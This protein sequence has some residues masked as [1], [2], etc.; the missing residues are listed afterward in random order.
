MSVQKFI[1]DNK[2]FQDRGWIHFASDPKLLEWVS[3][4]LP[5]ATSCVTDP[6]YQQWLRH[7][8]TWFVGVNALN[9]DLNGKVTGGVNLS[10][11]AV[12]FIQS[13]LSRKFVWDRA[14]VS[15][16]YPGYPART[17]EESE[18]SFNY[19]LRRDAAHVDGLLREGPQQRRF[20]REHHAFIMGIPMQEV[21]ATAAPV[22]VWEGSHHL[23]RE[24]FQ[25]I[26]QGHPPDTWKDIDVTQAY[27]ELRKTIFSRCTRLE[28]P[29]RP[30]ECYLI[31][32]LALHGMAPWRAAT[33]GYES[34]RM[35][36]YFRPELPA[37]S[38]W[39]SLP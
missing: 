4:S 29:A 33:R 12:D 37:P 30:G 10:G 18:S 27:T 15:V 34:G 11:K 14:Q 3:L 26:Y 36:C 39:L 22:V 21:P 17:D 1:E 7:G 31:H 6:E 28:L 32:R 9:N 20:L 5:A 25:N 23:V 19:R 38:D 24:A 16:C 35:I 13:Q 2:S 8:D